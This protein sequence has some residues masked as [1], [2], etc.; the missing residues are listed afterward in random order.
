[1]PETEETHVHNTAVDISKL[2]EAKEPG[3]MGGIIEGERLRRRRE[4]DNKLEA[5][6][7]GGNWINEPL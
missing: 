4:S 3:A 5:I 6:T 7:V 2:L 1:M